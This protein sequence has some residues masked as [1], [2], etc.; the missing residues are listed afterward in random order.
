MLLQVNLNTF[1]TTSNEHFMENFIIKTTE[2]VKIYS[3]QITTDQKEKK[4]KRKRKKNRHFICMELPSRFLLKI[5]LG[6]K[7][8]HMYENK[9]MSFSTNVQARTWLISVIFIH[10]SSKAKHVSFPQC[11]TYILYNLSLT[12]FINGNLAT[13]NYKT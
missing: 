6:S 10:I 9:I 11:D 7:I 1:L 12:I 3:R 8:S 5:V 13:K 2:R 4:K